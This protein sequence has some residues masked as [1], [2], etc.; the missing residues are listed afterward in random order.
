[1]NPST[2]EILM[3]L[4]AGTPIAGLCKDL[5]WDR[6]RFDAWWR[7]ECRRR[8]PRLTGSLRLAGLNGSVRVGRDGTGVPH[9]RAETSQDLFFGFGFAT[10]QDRLFQLDHQRRKARG[11]LA[12]VL[13]EQA[14]ESDILHR[15]LDLSGI[16]AR[17]WDALPEEVRDLLQAYTDGINAFLEATADVDLPIEFGLLGYRPEPWQPTD[18]LA[19]LGEFRWYLTGRFPVLVVPELVRRAVGDGPL[20][21]AFLPGEIDE[22]SILHPGEFPTV[23]G[24]GKPCPEGG[25]EGPGSNNW[26]VAGARTATGS[27]LVAS[28]PHIPFAAVSW[29]QEVC[30]DGGGFHVL[31]VALAG[32]PAV[33]IGRNRDVAWGITNNICSQRDL[34]QEKEDPAHPGCFLHDGRWEPATVR[35]ETFTVR[36]KEPV[37]RTVRSSRNGPLVD[38]LLPVAARSTGPVSVR[39]LGFE[40][41]G[42]LT[43]MLGMNRA[44]TCAEFREATRP[45]LVPTFSLVYADR[46]GTIAYH[47]AGGIPIREVPSRGYRPGWDPAHQWQGMIPFEDMPCVADP[48][49]GWVATANNRVA[50][51]DFPYPLSGVWASGYRARRCREFLESHP[52]LTVEDC[53]TLQLDCLSLRAVEGLPP[54][55]AVLADDGDPS[56][57][58]AFGLL[59]RW[60]GRMERTSVPAAIFDVF[61]A[62]WCRTVCAARLR[63]EAVD[64]ASGLAP[65][66]A[67]RLLH[68][69]PH[70][71]FA[72]ADRVAAMHR[73]FRESLREMTERLGP[74]ME[75]WAWGNLHRLQQPHFLSGRGDL[76]EL[77]DLSGMPID[78]NTA[79]T[80]S[81]QSD[82]EH[83][84]WLGAGYRMVAD[85]AD[86]E[87]NLL[88]VEI[89]GSSGHPGSPH[90]ADQLE[91][92]GCGEY[93]PIGIG[94]SLVGELLIEPAKSEA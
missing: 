76:G 87:T 66:L 70:G 33:M 29:W 53:R 92:W 37:R 16:A 1:M 7:E 5:G 35:E 91:S 27:P 21:Q 30:L 20:Y 63:A 31:G 73:T 15:T 62:R 47:A 34:Y 39:W 40:P 89:A 4:G 50:G 69:D 82:A 45:W 13:G 2:F 38:D 94:Q 51:D 49:R 6:P 28:D 10:A 41:C 93:R 14:L 9:V 74:D 83:R 46:T 65:G 25:S 71:W 52:R 81:N 56:V 22:E 85:L 32:V 55:L 79:C 17:E 3:R 23:P 54:L 57:R 36:G 77:L 61:F 58:Q 26:V 64:L 78:G 86:P 60:N 67:G 18:S 90:Y 88:A 8:V 12:E 44:R 42:F 24:S 68:D 72:D 75:D 84:A 43:A 11:R 59:E 80:C 19:V 48:Q